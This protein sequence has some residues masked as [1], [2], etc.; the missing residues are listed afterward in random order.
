MITLTEVLP[1]LVEDTCSDGVYIRWENDY[2]AIDQWYFR[3]N[4]ANIINAAS[5]ESF[6]KY[7]ETL[8]GTT[9]NFDILSKQYS[10]GYK[11]Y[12]TFDKVNTEGFKQLVRS[13]NVEVYLNS[14]W[15]KVDI[16]LESF[17]VEKNGAFGKIAIRVILPIT[18]VK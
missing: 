4:V 9:D 17:V 6:E 11:C 10:E 1:F 12:A 18:Y 5:G 7:V 8:L 2:A 16:A 15:I 3:G 13:K 14:V